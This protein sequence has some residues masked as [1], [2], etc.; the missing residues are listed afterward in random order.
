M[1]VS[2]VIIATRRRGGGGD[3]A[4]IEDVGTLPPRVR[5]PTT[6]VPT[7]ACRRN[8][9]DVGLHPLPPGE[10]RPRVY[11]I[12]RRRGGSRDARVYDIG[13]GQRSSINYRGSLATG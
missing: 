6:A 11:R 2:K 13:R 12:R 1:H 4:T 9:L 3:D 8:I 7:T 5:P 10:R